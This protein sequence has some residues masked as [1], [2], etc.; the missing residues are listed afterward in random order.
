MDEVS[1]SNRFKSVDFR[2]S[3]S[4]LMSDV[5]PDFKCYLFSG[6]YQ[7]YLLVQKNDVCHGTIAHSL[8]KT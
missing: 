8:R 2:I 1:E 6:L 3:V 5:E 4:S 7:E